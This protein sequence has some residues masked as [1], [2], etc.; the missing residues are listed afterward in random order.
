MGYSIAQA[1]LRYVRKYDLG[2]G[3]G[4]FGF[5]DHDGASDGVYSFLTFPEGSSPFCPS[6]RNERGA[7]DPLEY[8]SP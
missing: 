1:Y 8:S 5:V 3:R 4:D 7:V 2:I 6:I